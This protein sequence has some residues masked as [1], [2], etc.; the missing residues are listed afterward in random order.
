MCVCVCVCT[1]HFLSRITIVL[2]K[3]VKVG[4]MDNIFISRCFLFTE[5]NFWIGFA[6]I[7]S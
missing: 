5:F 3:S 4:V 6:F 7:K 1:A 2:S